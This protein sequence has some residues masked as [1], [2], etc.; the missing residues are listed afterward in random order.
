MSY[1]IFEEAT[2]AIVETVRH[3]PYRRTTEYKTMA[4]A[5]AALTRMHKKFVEKNGAAE[6][7]NGPLFNYG[8]AE[9]A[10]YHAKIERMVER[11]NM[12][13]GKK[14]KE[15]INTPA[16]MSPSCESYWSM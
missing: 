2:S 1:V 15:S 3:R 9:R 16:Y 11:V 10:H 8:V 6:E 4:A 5:K 12:M 7:E 14:Y 13:T